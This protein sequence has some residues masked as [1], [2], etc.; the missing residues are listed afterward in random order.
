M[1]QISCYGTRT[2]AAT[3]AFMGECAVAGRGAQFEVD[4]EG[5]RISVEPRYCPSLETK[6][7]RFPGRTHHIWLEPEG[8]YS[9][10]IYP[11]GLSCSLDIEDQHQLLQTIPGLEDAKLLVPAYSVEYDYIDPRELYSTLE[12]KKVR[13]LYLAGQINGT[14]GYE[15]AAAQGLLAG[16]NAAKPDRPLYTSRTDSYLGVLIDDLITKGTSEPYRMMTSRAEF[17]LHLRPDNA[18]F[19]LSDRAERD[20]LIT[21]ELLDIVESRNNILSRTKQALEE[22]ILS[23]TSW[24]KHGIEASQDGSLLPASAIFSRQNVTLEKIADIALSEHC[25]SACQLRKSA[26]YQACR[27]PMNAVSTA[28]YDFY[29]APY[30]EKQKALAAELHKDESISIPEWIDYEKMQMS[31]EDREKLTRVRP[32]NLAEA[33]RIPGVTPN[34]LLNVLHHVRKQERNK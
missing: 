23:A 10:V 19:R 6:F 34:A 17:R 13:G 25:E 5:N 2:T 22:T 11:N 12:T 15:E 8:L 21:N 33:Q 16:A 18:D 24:N 14:T 32:R 20:G 30:L 26:E 3:E 4:A 31:K 9:N 29:Y 28:L 7:K 1:E 27:S